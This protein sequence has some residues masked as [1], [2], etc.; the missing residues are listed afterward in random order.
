MG[1]LDKLADLTDSGCDWTCD[2]CGTNLNKQAGFNTFLG[3]WG[4]TSCGSM[5]DVSK[6]NIIP[7][8]GTKGYVS[9]IEHKDG[10]IEKVRFTKTREVHDFESPN[11]KKGSV[12]RKR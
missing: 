9:K 7:P 11:G 12:W 5:N 2:F 3:S 10:T 4:C 8:E 1:L 6:N